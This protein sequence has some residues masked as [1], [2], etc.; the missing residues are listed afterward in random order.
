MDGIDGPASP[1]FVV[2]GPIEWIRLT[3]E[4]AHVRSP[5]P[6]RR[7]GRWAKAWDLNRA[8]VGDS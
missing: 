7:V 5:G 1:G 3:T 4:I 6:P 2:S 8:C